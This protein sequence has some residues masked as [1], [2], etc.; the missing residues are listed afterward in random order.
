MAELSR[1][2]LLPWVAD[3]VEPGVV[4][5]DAVDTDEG[6]DVPWLVAGADVESEPLDDPD[7]ADEDGVEDEE[8]EAGVVVMVGAGAT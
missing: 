2:T 4:E 7:G 5:E 6:D 1:E 3:G 8:V